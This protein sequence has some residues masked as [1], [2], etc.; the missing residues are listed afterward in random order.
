MRSVLFGS[1]SFYENGKRGDQRACST[2]LPRPIGCPVLIG[3]KGQRLK[4][5]LKEP[6]PTEPTDAIVLGGFQVC[7]R[8]RAGVLGDRHRQDIPDI[9]GVRVAEQ[10]GWVR[11]GAAGSAS[12]RLLYGKE[13]VRAR[14]LD[15]EWACKANSKCHT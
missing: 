15:R 8:R 2:R 3:G 5:A 9:M 4:D 12:A 11:A 1:T 10:R 14:R 7:G 13:R 6:G